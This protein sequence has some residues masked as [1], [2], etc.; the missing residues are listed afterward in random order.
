MQRV[1]AALERP[2]AGYVAAI[3]AARRQIGD[4]SGE[5]ARQLGL[6]VDRIGDLTRDE[7]RELHDETFAGRT[8]AATLA[9][10]APLLDRLERDRNPFAHLVRALCC[11]LLRS[12]S[13]AP[14][15]EGARDSV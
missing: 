7:L 13:A 10:L 5:A 6:F 4:R 1:A 2:R 11:L 15:G 3:E 12:A 8:P 9:A 14:A